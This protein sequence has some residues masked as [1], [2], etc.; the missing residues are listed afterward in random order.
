M[1]PKEGEAVPEVRFPEFVEEWENHKL[2]E[3]VNIIMGQSPNGENYTD[4]S[5]DYILVQ[6]NADIKNGWVLPRVWTTQVTKTA[7]KGDIILSVRA[8]V[9]DVGKT[10]YD[11]VIG[12][13]V[14]AIQGNDFIFQLLSKM[15]N[16]GFWIKFS[17]G[18]TFE[19]INSTDLREAAIKIPAQA[20][21]IK[22]GNFFKQLD[23]VIALHEQELEALQQTKNAFLQKMFV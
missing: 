2:G 6:G 23:Q 20:E 18:S 12:R 11:V 22:I 5:E 9:G 16:D 17:T 14:A 4:N 8:P 1:F 21:Q 13:G 7:Q 10:D 15:K 19:S 3:V